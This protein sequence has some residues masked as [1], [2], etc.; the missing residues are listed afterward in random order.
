L[1]DFSVI[2]EWSCEIPPYETQDVDKKEGFFSRFKGIF[3]GETL[4]FMN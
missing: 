2:A 3:A 4:P 1:G